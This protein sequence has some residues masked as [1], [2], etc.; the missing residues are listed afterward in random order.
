[1]QRLAQLDKAGF[2]RQNARMSSAQQ[3]HMSHNFC[4]VQAHAKINLTLDVLGRRADGYHEL[5][6]IMQTIELCDTL[7]LS[8]SADNHVHMIC[9]RPELGNAENLAARAAEAVR[10]HIGSLQGL[11]IELYKRI[12]MAAGL[13]GGSSDAAAVLLALR[14]WWWLDLSQADLLGIAAS[15]GSDVPF[16]LTGGLALCEGRGERIT[17]LTSFW[18]QQMRWLILLK[19]AIMISTAAVFRQL[20]A[21]DYTGGEHSRAV[22]EA[23]QAGRLPGREDLHNGLERSVMTRYPEVARA[24]KDMLNAGAPHV[25]LSGSGPSLYTFFADLAPALSV[26]QQLQARGYDVYLS[27]PYSPARA[28]KSPPA[29]SSSTSWLEL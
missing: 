22:Q 11:K 24:R 9:S 8:A 21:T 2:S 14:R 13:G 28:S 20:P 12:P 19:P 10:Q 15:L 17:P 25:R 27:R 4:F 6:T 7:C 26:Q 16:F 5:A 23:L 29:L 3:V 18:P 1:M